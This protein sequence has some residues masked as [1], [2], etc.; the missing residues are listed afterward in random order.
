M[1][2]TA[3]LGLHYYPCRQ[4]SNPDPSACSRS[5][6]SL[7]AGREGFVFK[8]CLLYRHK[9]FYTFFYILCKIMQPMYKCE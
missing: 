4:M 1:L 6:F 7:P 2:R 9:L 3:I 5:T 8:I